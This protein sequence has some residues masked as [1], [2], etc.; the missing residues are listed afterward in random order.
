MASQT[1]LYHQRFTRIG[2]DT[3]GWL[4]VCVCCSG[5]HIA[6][7]Y[8]H[9]HTRMRTC[10]YAC[11][12]VC[13]C[14]CVCL[15]VW[16]CVCEICVLCANFFMIVLQTLMASMFFCYGSQGCQS[17]GKHGNHTLVTLVIIWI[18]AFHRTPIFISWQYSLVR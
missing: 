18:I 17:I 11:M 15:H 14:V 10:L 12:C 6:C 1:A 9:I 13:V 4:G 2:S 7:M 16:M 3:H 8:S 5:E